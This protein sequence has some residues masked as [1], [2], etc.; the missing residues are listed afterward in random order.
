MK[1]HG[2]LGHYHI[3]ENKVDPGPAFQWDYVV[4]GARQ[5]L[6]EGRAM[7]NTRGNARMRGVFK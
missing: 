3:Q 4:E 2:L 5:L 7:G 6:E 1:Y